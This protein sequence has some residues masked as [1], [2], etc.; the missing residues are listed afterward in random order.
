[1]KKKKNI[2]GWP[3]LEKQNEE[4]EINLIDGIKKDKDG[5]YF[6]DL[7]SPKILRKEGEGIRQDTNI[8]S[9]TWLNDAETSYL[10]ILEHVKNTID[11]NINSNDPK[12]R[13]K[14]EWLKSYLEESKRGFEND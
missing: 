11:N 10:R 3:F 4:Q 1:M 9:I 12:I 8:F 7:L 2:D 6:L 5:V 13:Q 14:Y